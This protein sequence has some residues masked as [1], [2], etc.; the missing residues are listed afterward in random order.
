M[1]TE[2]I[3]MSEAGEDVSQRIN[4]QKQYWGVHKLLENSNKEGPGGSG[5][6]VSKG[7]ALLR[8]MLEWW[9]GNGWQEVRV[10]F[11]LNHN[12]SEEW[13]E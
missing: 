6:G 5:K 1:D 10:C 11:F 7:Q 12:N 13:Q 4:Y 9:F 2:D 3:A 8:A